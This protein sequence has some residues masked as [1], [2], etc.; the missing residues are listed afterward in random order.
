[1]TTSSTATTDAV[2]T[3]SVTLA[4]DI[5]LPI[6]AA[7]AGPPVTSTAMSA[8]KPAAAEVRSVATASLSADPDVAARGIG[9][10]AAR[11]SDETISGAPAT[12]MLDSARCR[13]DSAAARS[14]VASADPSRRD[15]T[16]IA[17]TR[18]PPGKDFNSSAALA[19]S[20]DSGSRRGGLSAPELDP[21]R[22]MNAPAAATINSATAQERRCV[23]AAAMRSHTVM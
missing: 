22:A 12:P 9:A 10:T 2:T 8:G 7:K 17:G 3:S 19:D 13:A 11:P 6:S 5:A 1:M 21:A 16:R 20:A 4:L 14:P 23:T 18:S 15:N